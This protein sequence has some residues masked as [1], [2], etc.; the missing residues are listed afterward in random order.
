MNTAKNKNVC[1]YQICCHSTRKMTVEVTS[2]IASATKTS[3]NLVE[4]NCFYGPHF[5]QLLQKEIEF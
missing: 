4:D 5:P 1:L 2:F 3:Y